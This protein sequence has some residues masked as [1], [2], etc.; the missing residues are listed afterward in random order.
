MRLTGDLKNIKDAWT[1]FDSK[2]NTGHFFAIQLPAACNG[3]TIKVK[4]RRDG[5]R[6]ISIPAEGDFLVTR[7][8]NLSGP[9]MEIEVDG[10]TLLKVDTTALIPVGEKA[11]KPTKTD[12]GGYGKREEMID[13]FSITWSGKKAV[14]KG[15]FKKYKNEQKLTTEGYYFPVGMSDWYFDNVPRKA[16]IK[17]IDEKTAQ[18]IVF[19]VEDLEKPI[20][21]EYN[22]VTVFEIDIS[23]MELPSE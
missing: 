4:G 21:C 1:A 15:K 17:N 20:V 13:N 12:F 18:D 19:K 23:Q 5:D 8:E 6:E 16:G 9:V 3:K 7:M 22:G 10:K 14:A 11:F 2:N